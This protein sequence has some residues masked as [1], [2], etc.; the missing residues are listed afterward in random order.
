L[1][2]ITIIHEGH[3]LPDVDA[4]RPARD[5]S[6]HTLAAIENVEPLQARG[7]GSPWREGAERGDEHSSDQWET[8]HDAHLQAPVTMVTPGYAWVTSLVHA[9]PSWAPPRRASD[10]AQGAMMTPLYA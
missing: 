1:E 5:I 7:L 6:G 8:F 9:S 10:H 2:Q 3:G 4:G